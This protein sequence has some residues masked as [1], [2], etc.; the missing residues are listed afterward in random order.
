MPKL[1]TH[2]GASKRFKRTASGKF[3]RGS[4]F[5]RHILTSKTTKRKRSLRGSKAVADQDS[6]KLKRML[7][8]D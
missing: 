3:L 6:A 5:K 7:P 2:K 4:A 8:Y 1:K